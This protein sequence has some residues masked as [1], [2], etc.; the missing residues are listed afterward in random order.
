M[1]K[2]KEL[3][4]A[5]AMQNTLFSMSSQF[6]WRGCVVPTRRSFSSCRRP[7]ACDDR[8]VGRPATM[9]AVYHNDSSAHRRF[10]KPS[11]GPGSL[12][13]RLVELVSQRLPRGG[14]CS[15]ACGPDG[16][17]ATSP[18]AG[19]AGPR[20]QPGRGAVGRCPRVPSLRSVTGGKRQRPPGGRRARDERRCV[21]EERCRLAAGYRSFADRRCLT[22]RGRG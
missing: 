13:C 22:A 20:S 4:S 8:C 7:A 21:T 19:P 16:I 5:Q 6:S 10:L 1:L 18:L 15:T 9:R 2:K 14:G 3:Y 17:G 11:I 12:A